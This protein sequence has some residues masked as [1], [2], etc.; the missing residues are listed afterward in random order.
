MLLSLVESETLN[1]LLLQLAAQ[2][3]HRPKVVLHRDDYHEIAYVA[4]ILCRVVGTLQEAEA[5]QIATTAFTEG[6]DVV[7]SCPLEAAEH[8]KEELQRYGLTVTLETV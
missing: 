3:Q 6:Q 7:V 4:T 8:Y 1:P 5:Q 2:F